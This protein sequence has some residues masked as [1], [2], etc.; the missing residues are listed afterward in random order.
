MKKVSSNVVRHFRLS[1][2]I[3]LAFA[4]SRV[5]AQTK[6]DSASATQAGAV[7]A[8]ITQAIDET[9][10][11][12]LKGNVHPL[13]RPEFDQ[14]PAPSSQP[15]KRMLLLLQRSPEQEAALEEL[16]LE[17]Q[18]KNSPNF[19]KWLTP[20][21]FGAQFGPADRDI[22]TVTDWLAR[23]GFQV[24]RVS[25]GRTVIEFSGNAAQVQSAFHTEIHTFVVDGE[26]R[27]ANIR[28]P[29]IPAALAPVVRGVVSLHNFPR[30]TFR[31]DAGLHNVTRDEHGVPQ[32]SSV[33]GCGPNGTKQ[34]F[35]VGPADFAKI[36]NIPASLDGTGV[37]IGI[38][39]DSNIDPNDA[40]SFRNV[41]GLTPATGPTIVVDGTDPGISGAGGDEGEADLDVQ[42]SG[43]VAPKATIDFV[44]AGGTLTALG[45]DLAAFHII[46]YNLTDVMSESFGNCEPALGSTGVA[47]YDDVWKQAA[48]Q[49]ITVMVSAG[50]DGSAAC[51]NFN[52]QSSA[53]SGLAVNGVASTPFNVAVGGTDF[54]DVGN[55]AAFWNTSNA[56]GTRESA[57]G[58]IPETTWNDS[59][60]ATA[61]STNLGTVCA[62]A[63]ATNIVAGSGGPSAFNAKPTWQNGITPNDVAT[64]FPAG[65]RDLPDVSLFASNGPQTFSFYPFCEAD[66]VPAGGNPSCAT[67][68]AFAIEGAGGTSASSPAFAGIMALIV[69][70]MGGRQGN[71]NFVLYKLAQTAANSCNSSTQPLSPPATCI[72]YDVTKGNNSVPCTGGTSANCSSANGVLVDPAHTTTPAWT[73]AAGYDY[74]TGLGSVN[75]TN[76]ATAW[77]TAVGNFTGT[78]TSLTLNGGTSVNIVHGTSVTATATVASTTTGTPT[79]DVSLLGPQGT[80]NSGI[81]AATLTG[82]SPDTANLTTTFLPGGSYSVTAHYAG[83][84]VFA[85][86]NSSA[87]PVVVSPE[88]S[89]LQMSV[90]MLDPNSGSILNTNATSYTY[91]SFTFLRFDILNS[92]TN[93]CQIL[94]NGTTTGCA[95]DAQGS[96]TVTDNGNALDGGTFKINSEGSAEDQA[97]QLTAGVHTLSATYSGDGNY[98]PVTTA[99]TDAVT[100]SKAATAISL[101]VSPTSVNTGQTVTLTAN[102]AT[103]S[104]GAGPS[105]TVTFSSCGTPPCTAT[106]VPLAA[107]S[108]TFAS[109]TATLSTAFTTP[110]TQTITATYAA[111]D[112]N[113][114]GSGPSNSVTVTVTQATVGSFTM[115]AGPATITTTAGGSGT[116]ATGTSAITITPSGGFASAVTV[117]CG[118]IPGVTCSTLTIAAGSTTGTLTINVNDPSSAM[119]AMVAPET[120]NLWAANKPSGANKRGA[121]GLWTLSAGTGFAALFLLFLPGGRKRFRAALGLGLVCILTFTL[122]CGGGSSGGGGGGGGPTATTTHLTVSATKVANSPT[123]SLTVSATVSGGTPTGSVQFLVDGAALGGTTPLTGGSTGNITVTAAQAPTFLQLVGTHTVSAKYLGDS[124]TS[125]S[126][127]GTLNVT[128]T[129]T[130]S[131]AITGTSGSATATNNVAL[132]IN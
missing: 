123:A 50:D 77:P 83:D 78:T 119:T 115:A 94:V 8:R 61:T 41:F 14:G 107:T 2:V 17:Q 104:V 127:S 131:V 72:F 27:S 103:Q 79:G 55:Q 36:Y 20:Q 18:S 101:G 117:A 106:L 108:N 35:I 67:S 105:G 58:Y 112:T 26:T 33:G 9:Q 75:V 68:G 12:P 71:A 126:Q 6:P 23:Q 92:T 80:I 95:L 98:K 42:T 54:D 62:G 130:T 1:L 37:T 89:R 124:T 114:V 69:Q 96:V 84:G 129:G 29:Q 34:C 64:G 132:T 65:R 74:A 111:G 5:S 121:K 13:A 91:G 87:I 28:D 4:G 88:A 30:R 53:A 73:T 128:I 3:F 99:V 116:M 21:Q 56:T 100:V 38:V 85:P 32:F 31:R 48:A 24:V 90:V 109:A 63:L 120:K 122:G 39:G 15:M 97:L 43:A 10:L 19:H 47:F 60:A 102:I 57:L 82:T 25:N 86:S 45:T 110:G 125:P 66:S 70:K 22:Q 93:P 52:T 81:N 40:V 46:D 11:V 51:D 113:Y 59:C 44:V 16:M 49:G 118:T 76:L 7:P